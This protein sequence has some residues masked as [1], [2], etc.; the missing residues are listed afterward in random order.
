MMYKI[1]VNDRNYNEVEYFNAD[2]LI[3]INLVLDGF[4]NKLFN[5][6]VFEM[7]ENNA[8]VMNHSVIR[9]GEHI[10]GI[11]VL[12]NNKTY[13]KYKKRFL[14]KCIPDD[15]RLPSFLVP[16]EI[17][18]MQFSK[19]QSNLYVT[20]K[21]DSW[22]NKFPIGKINQNLGCVNE[23]T[24]FYEYQLYCKSLYASIQQFNKEAVQK[25]KE[26][27][28]SHYIESI[29]NNYELRDLSEEY[30]FTIDS[31]NTT[32]YDDAFHISYLSEN[33]QIIKIHI[34]NVTL[35]MNELDLWDSFSTRVSTIY[36]PDRKRPMLPTIMSECL[37]SLVQNNLKLAFTIELKI[38]NGDIKE[39][40]Y[41][42]SL[43]KVAKNFVYQE[44]ELLKNQHY[45]NLH[46]TLNH[47]SE[48]YKYIHKINNSYDVISYGMIMMNY[49]CAKKLTTFSSGIFRSSSIRSTEFPE[50]LHENTYKFLKIWNSTAG[51]YDL[52]YE[53]KSHE[54][55]EFDSYIHITSP[56]RRIVDLINISILQEKQGLVPCNINRN[57]FL[58]KWLGSVEYINT[59][60]R[61]IRKIQQECTL[62]EM[63]TNQPEILDKEF[64]SLV[65]DKI[66]RSDDLF[67]YIVYIEE[68]KTASRIT[69]SN[70]LTNY[71][72]HH[73]KIFM[74][75]DEDSLKKKIRIHLIK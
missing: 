54:T 53:K 12:K 69:C 17:K 56:I 35:W 45:K 42:N 73:F 6:D 24:N 26:K 23:L 68:L 39:V 70:D 34:A 9:S 3:K 10:P 71:S 62:L 38:E 74:F 40:E 47:L 57:N 30:T 75:E 64:K 49:F 60:I 16:Y 11:L 31:H 46:K 32:D 58:D 55:M 33:K 28:E 41:Y 61:S 2:K 63:C 59:T 19:V 50:N 52:F 18:K 15:K 51:Q 36:L 65:F 37:C 5:H 7:N 14:Y 25:L 72:Y 43:I 29:K 66:E 13:G 8:V 22:E 1:I 27:T 44:K 48:K 21:Y 20:L 67:Q 4:S